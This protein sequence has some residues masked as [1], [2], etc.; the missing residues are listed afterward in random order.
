[1]RDERCETH[2]HAHAHALAL[3]HSR[4]S[5]PASF[6]SS[7]CLLGTICSCCS[8]RSSVADD[9]ISAFSTASCRCALASLCRFAPVSSA[10]CGSDSRDLCVCVC[11]CLCVSVCVSVSPWQDLTTTPA[12]SFSPH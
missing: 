2:T 9:F 12:C 5:S 3:P 4:N 11:V 7:S 10:S 8:L 6:A 1:M